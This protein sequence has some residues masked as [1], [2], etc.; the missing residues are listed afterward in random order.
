MAISCR[1]TFAAIRKEHGRSPSLRLI[2][3]GTGLAI[4]FAG[5]KPSS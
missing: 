5:A 3:D 2:E 1:P 4:A